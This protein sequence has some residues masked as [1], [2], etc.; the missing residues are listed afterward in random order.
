MKMLVTGGAGFIGSN[1]AAGILK[2][3]HDL[4]VVD[5]FDDYYTGKEKNLGRVGNK[6]DFT[7]LKGDVTDKEFMAKSAEGVD[8]VYH[9]AAQPGVR[10]SVE[11]PQK[12]VK[13]NIL[14]TVNVLKAAADAG[15]KKVVFASSSSVFGKAEYMPIDE[16]HPKNPISPY[17]LSKLCCEH[18]CKLYEELAG[19]KTVALRY[20]TVYGPSQ[21]PDMAI[22]IFIR[23]ALKNETISVFGDGKQTRDFTYIGDIVDATMLA[24][25]KQKADGEDFNLG[26]GHN[27]DV[28][29]LVQKIAE[30]CGSESKITH[31]DK[32]TGDV[33][34]TLADNRKARKILGWNPETSLDDGLKKQI[35]Y[36]SGG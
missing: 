9:L 20:F 30:L 2:D 12:T 35:E 15:V 6:K 27:I 8:L 34:H 21:R 29:S 19:I 14:G 17:G 36:Q 11:N 16:K 10:I 1:L 31:E 25:E 7:F 18:Y 26:G 5:N 13:A 32:K 4:V 22:N 23:K 28:N 33:D 3:G 24:G